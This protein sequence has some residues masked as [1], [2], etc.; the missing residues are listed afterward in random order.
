MHRLSRIIVFSSFLLGLCGCSGVTSPDSAAEPKPLPFSTRRAAISDQGNDTADRLGPIFPPQI[1]EMDDWSMR[2]T[3]VDALS[4]MG[5]PGVPLLRRDLDSSNPEI[6]RQAAQ[7]LGNMGPDAVEATSQLIIL[8]D[9][10][11][12]RVRKAAAMALGKIGPPAAAAAPA[13]VRILHE[14][15]SKEQTSRGLSPPP[16]RQP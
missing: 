11:N 3:L 5:A 14:E 10:D 15:I 9:D 7:I 2:E 8:L 13:L 16:P 4:R 12:R 6:R 1:R